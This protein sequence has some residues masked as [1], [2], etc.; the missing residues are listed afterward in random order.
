MPRTSSDKL[1]LA[2]DEIASLSPDYICKGFHGD[3]LKCNCIIKLQDKVAL[4][5]VFLAE[6]QGFLE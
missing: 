4:S 1:K 5:K 6:G 2:L 3:F